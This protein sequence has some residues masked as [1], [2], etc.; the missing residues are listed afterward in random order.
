MNR[1][2][3]R[4]PF[5]WLVVAVAL[6]VGSTVGL[7]PSARAAGTP[8]LTIQDAGLRVGGTLAISGTGWTTTDGTAGSR[9]AVKIDE[10]AYTRLPAEKVHDNLQVWALIE[11]RADGSFSTSITLPTATN[12]TPGFTAGT[13]SL[14]FLT[15]SLQAGDEV[16]TL[17]SADLTV[18]APADTVTRVSVNR[19]SSA[20]GSAKVATVA[21]TSAGRPLAGT[22][23]LRDGSW[24]KSVAVPAGGTVKVALPTTL[25]VGRHRLAAT[26]AGRPGILA[27]TGA[28]AHTVVKA[29]SASGLSLN[30]KK[31]KKSKR[32]VATVTVR[33]AGIP[34]PTGTVRIYDG[35]KVISTATLSAP[36]KGSITITLPKLKKG[37]HKIKVGYAGSSAVNASASA[38]VK[39]KVTK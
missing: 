31:I 15:G 19:S 21:L 1:V 24:A 3:S 34:G 29:T 30:K 33:A 37:T 28:V 39:L 35:S 36:A 8:T 2:R 20:Y 27:S 6:V 26:F 13:H 16:R 32:A 5:L 14:R 23:V 25:P 7:P 38:V 18:A 22:V 9:I 11:A 10:G 4:R 17:R 12:S